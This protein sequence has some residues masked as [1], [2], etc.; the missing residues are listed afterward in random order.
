MVMESGDGNDDEEEVEGLAVAGTRESLA[1]NST[2][3]YLLMKAC[4]LGHRTVVEKLLSVGVKVA[5][6]R[7]S[8]EVLVLTVR[9][10]PL[11]EDMLQFRQQYNI[12]LPPTTDVP[13]GELACM[14]VGWV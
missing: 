4:C 6:Y 12:Q 5:E 1:G 10:L 13:L 8:D 14:L 3:K 9:W 7:N 11:L 2:L